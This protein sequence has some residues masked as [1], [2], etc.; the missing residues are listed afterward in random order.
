MR[1]R[2]KLTKETPKLKSEGKSKVG[3]GV[4]KGGPARHRA[5]NVL[6]KK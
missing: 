6:K 4:W 2:E 3:G 5:T 1:E